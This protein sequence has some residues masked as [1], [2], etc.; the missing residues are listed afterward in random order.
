MMMLTKRLSS[1]SSYTDENNRERYSK[2]FCSGN[3]PTPSTITILE[4]MKEH[5]QEQ[6]SKNRPL[7][8]STPIKIEPTATKQEPLS[9][10][11]AATT[12]ISSS[13]INGSNNSGID[14]KISLAASLTTD[15]T[16]KSK[17]SLLTK[18]HLELRQIQKELQYHEAM[19][20][21][22]QKLKTNQKV[23]NGE[24]IHLQKRTTNSNT[25]PSSLNSQHVKRPITNNTSSN[26]ITKQS[27][28][29][30]Q[31]QL[32]H[33]KPFSST[34]PS[35]T[36][37]NNE[38]SFSKQ[39]GPSKLPPPPQQQPHNR[40]SVQ[41]PSKS[42]H[43]NQ[44]T[45]NRSNH[46]Q[47]SSSSMPQQA[48][49]ISST[50]PSQVSN[51]TSQGFSKNSLVS[52]QKKIR[53]VNSALIKNQ[54]DN[55]CCYLPIGSTSAEQH[56]LNAKLA[57]RKQLEQTLLQ[58]PTPKPSTSDLSFIPGINGWSEFL[59]MIGV[60]QALQ[61]YNDS[62][63]R[64]PLLQQ[65]LSGDSLTTTKTSSPFMCSQC[66]TDWSVTWHTDERNQQDDDT[67]NNNVLCDRCMKTNQKK[68]LKQDHSNRLR[69]A[70]IKALQQEKD[71]EAK[72]QNTTTTL[73]SSS[74]SSSS[75]VSNTST[76]LPTAQ[77]SDHKHNNHLSKP[78]SAK[79]QQ[80]STK[81]NQ[82]HSFLSTKSN[83]PSSTS[84]LKASSSS[85]SLRNNASSPSTYSLTQATKL[86]SSAA[87]AATTA[88]LAA[89][90]NT[91]NVS[92]EQ[93]KMFQKHFL[94]NMLPFAGG[95][96]SPS[97]LAQIPGLASMRQNPA[98]TNY[99][100]DM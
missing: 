84:Q 92:A 18:K 73:L 99:L 7:S 87:S 64:R 72:F 8:N 48:T 49:R 44:Y 71:L 74:S 79:Q 42:P 68:L 89:A 59:A 14:D 19:L 1:S 85:S 45:V 61:S 9:F 82:H 20:T 51:N 94:S 46:Q 11:N 39:L 34:Q 67:M 47:K 57:L 41:P 35:T 52:N 28:S 80:H 16:T 36:K 56:L 12:A 69:Q 21:L 100:L 78:S 5:E 53:Q 24:H 77:L 23:V 65:S 91:T 75:S 2:R 17:Q 97:T 6:K 66:N 10:N 3:T 96:I 30:Q 86:S 98:L 95:N 70:F 81:T 22:M 58:I 29:Q 27:T 32:Q 40:P 93:L 88:A 62:L 60:E 54:I 83:T 43:P 25:P 38:Q 55:E 15:L 63:F 4:N 13:L 33:T 76:T 26:S 90:L 31:Q 37:P 50:M